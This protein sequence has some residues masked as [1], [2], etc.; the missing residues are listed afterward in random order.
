VARTLAVLTF[1][2]QGYTNVFVDSLPDPDHIEVFRT[3]ES[4]YRLLV[5]ATDPDPARR[6]A[7]AAEMAEQRMITT[8]TQADKLRLVAQT[9]RAVW[10]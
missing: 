4:F 9:A 10:G 8:Q 5:R 2:F 3:Y 1:D 7:S 6:F